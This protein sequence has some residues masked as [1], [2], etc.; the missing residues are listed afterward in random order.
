MA[1]RG[2][3]RTPRGGGKQR[4]PA[5][6][7]A[8]P[9]N[10]SKENVDDRKRGLLI[11]SEHIRKFMDPV[12]QR[13]TA[14]IRNFNCRVLKKGDEFY[15]VESGLKNKDRRGVWRVWAKA[16]FGGN[17]YVPHEELEKFYIQHRCNRKDYEAVR[18][19]WSNDKG[20]FYMWNIKVVEIFQTPIY[21]APRSGED[22]M[23]ITLFKQFDQHVDPNT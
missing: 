7:P 14:E 18:S 22:S 15:L 4:K 20:G 21:V 6:S 8:A 17:Q 23:G 19:N 3:P 9:S 16:Q 13:K 5:A 1:P 12:L 10:E 2:T 11:S